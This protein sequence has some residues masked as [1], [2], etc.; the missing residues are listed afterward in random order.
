MGGPLL[1]LWGVTAG[2]PVLLPCNN[3]SCL[4]SLA[5]LAGNTRQIVGL[6]SKWAQWVP[7]TQ[8][9]KSSNEYRGSTV[10]GMRWKT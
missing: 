2:N 5:V 10:N 9:N 1:M 4:P 7:F 3:R 8:P 6:E